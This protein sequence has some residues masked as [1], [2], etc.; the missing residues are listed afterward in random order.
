M[1]ERVFLKRLRQELPRW[2]EQG[3]VAPEYRNVIL[4]DIA[5]R[6][7]GIR[8]TPLAFGVLGVLLFGTGVISFFAANWPLIPKLVKLAVL[9]GAMWAAFGGSSPT[10]CCC[11]ASFSM[12][13]TSC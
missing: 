10:L 3:W 1:W 9:F 7:G 12:A 4:D 6:T 5:A 2:V 13:P 11:L 8:H